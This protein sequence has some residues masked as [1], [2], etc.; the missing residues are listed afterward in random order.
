MKSKLLL[1][2]VLLSLSAPSFAARE[3]KGLKRLKK[4]GPPIIVA[5]AAYFVW[6][7]ISRSNEISNFSLYTNKL[8]RF[9]EAN[10]N[11]SNELNNVTLHYQFDLDASWSPFI[12]YSVN[13]NNSNLFIN[14]FRKTSSDSTGFGLIARPNEKIAIY[15][16][17]LTFNEKQAHDYTN[18]NLISANISF[19]F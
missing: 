18:Q 6:S 12:E 7:K 8:D 11:E 14:D 17:Y 2:I 4:W 19:R 3:S 15:F 5:G 10:Q 13:S 1:T 9:G 16:E